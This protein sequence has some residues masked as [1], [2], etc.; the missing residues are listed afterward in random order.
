MIEKTV[1]DYLTATLEV[2]VCMEESE[3]MPTE[4]VLVEKTGAGEENHIKSATL[5]VQSY[6]QTLFKAAELNVKV[7]E[8]MENIIPLN[9]ISRCNLNTDYNFTDT[10]RKK[11]RYQ[12]VFDIT[13]Y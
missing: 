10:Q 2:K 9:D 5:V 8:A 3:K 11:Y 7:K 1:L 4:Y 6:A 12:A 13:H